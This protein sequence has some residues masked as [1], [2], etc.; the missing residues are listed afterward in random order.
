MQPQIAKLASRCQ[1]RTQGFA[2]LA[3]LAARTVTLPCEALLEKPAQL[4]FQT[5]C[6]SLPCEALLLLARGTTQILPHTTMPAHYTMYLRR[7]RLQRPKD[8]PILTAAEE[9]EAAIHIRKLLEEETIPRGDPKKTRDS[10]PSHDTP[11]VTTCHCKT[12][13]SMADVIHKDASAVISESL[14]SDSSSSEGP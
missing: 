6:S 7:L 14:K 11:P 3:R 9:Q 1:C 8:M 2:R 5:F 12:V 4:F 13:P 10:T